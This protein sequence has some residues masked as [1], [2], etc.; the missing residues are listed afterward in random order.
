[1]K[2]RRGKQYAEFICPECGWVAYVEVMPATRFDPS[3]LA[4]DPP[5]ECEECGAGMEDVEES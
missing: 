3:C 2:T 5:E 1:M 4:T